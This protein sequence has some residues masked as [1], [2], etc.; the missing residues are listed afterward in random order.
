MNI[1]KKQNLYFKTKIVNLHYM[2]YIKMEGTFLTRIKIYLYF[3]VFIYFVSKN[4]F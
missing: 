3:F 1:K 4:S 2:Y